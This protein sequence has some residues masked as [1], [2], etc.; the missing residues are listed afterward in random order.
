[1]MPDLFRGL[2]AFPI[3]PADHQGH[4]DAD[5]LSR[6]VNRLVA[7]DVDSICVLGSTG[8][9]AYL[10]RTERRR[11]VE[12]A[13][14]C[15]GRRLPLLVGVGAIRTDE[16]QELARD[17]EAAGADGLLLA[18][19]SYTP[20]HEEEVFQHFVTVAGATALPL[21]IYNNP[22]TTHFTFTDALVARLA[23]VPGIIAVKNPAP[24]PRDA[25]ATNQALRAAVPSG[26]AIGYSG[27]WHAPDAVLAG[28]DAWYSVV[29]GL[30]P[31]PALRLLR[32]AQARDKVEVARWHARF[33]GLWDLFKE[34]GSLRMIYAAAAIFDI[35]H[36]EPPRPI[37]PLAD[38]ACRRV[39]QALDR[40]DAARPDM[41]DGGDC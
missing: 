8:T 30:L 32:A 15:I 40:L 37:L 29:G 4:V 23:E 19:V 18:P 28:G 7:A 17:A 35:C 22:S 31:A 10:T 39:I 20:L 14:G 36:A 2:S 26:F 3:T 41:P 24:L 27:D 1:M 11:A 9:S 12:A 13:A 33:R 21:C 34:F 16:A 5:G 25:Q 6:L 38:D